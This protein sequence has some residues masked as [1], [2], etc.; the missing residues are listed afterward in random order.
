MSNNSYKLCA[1]QE[2]DAGLESRGHHKRGYVCTQS[3]AADQQPF[4]LS[5]LRSLVNGAAVVQSEECASVCVSMWLDVG[6]WVGVQT[7]SVQI[8]RPPAK[9][10]VIVLLIRQRC[11][12]SR[13]VCVWPWYFQD[14]ECLLHSQDSNRETTTDPA[15]VSSDTQG[16]NV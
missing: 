1:Q 12:F 4:A 3:E 13:C 6:A 16:G 8:Y 9:G 15:L 7:Y 5:D 10:M 14:G 2:K 11:C